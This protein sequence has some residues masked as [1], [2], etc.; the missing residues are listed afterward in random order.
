MSARVAILWDCEVLK[1][2][3]GVVIFPPRVSQR[4]RMRMAVK[5]GQKKLK[6]VSLLSNRRKVRVEKFWPPPLSKRK[7]IDTYVAL[8]VASARVRSFKLE[9]MKATSREMRAIGRPP[10]SFVKSLRETIAKLSPLRVVPLQYSEQ[11]DPVYEPR[12]IASMA[13]DSWLRGGEL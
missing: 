7:R 11:R 9:S 10:H 1:Q 8:A 12:M 4:L 3:M 5:T 6:F 13:Q 2:H